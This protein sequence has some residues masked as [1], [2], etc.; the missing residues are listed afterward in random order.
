MDSVNQLVLASFWPVFVHFLSITVQQLY[1]HIFCS[2]YEFTPFPHYRMNNHVLLE[3]SIC[4]D[5]TFLDAF[6]QQHATADAV[7]TALFLRN[8]HVSRRFRFRRYSEAIA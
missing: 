2:C 7:D 5:F 1:F 6:A 3:Q 4:N 8:V